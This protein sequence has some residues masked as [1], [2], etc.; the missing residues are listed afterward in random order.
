M[1][2]YDDGHDRY[3]DDNYSDEEEEFDPEEALENFCNYIEKHRRHF[4]GRGNFRGCHD[5][6]RNFHDSNRNRYSD[7]YNDKRQHHSQYN[8]D[9]TTNTA[10]GKLQNT[11]TGMS[12]HK[13]DKG[14]THSSS[15]KQ[16]QVNEVAEV[17][18]AMPYR[19]EVELD[20]PEAA[21][22]IRL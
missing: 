3:D 9:N 11:N 8:D 12:N 22:D 10:F 18:A 7:R 6:F 20:K 4:R 5:N 1:D 19:D 2:R 16:T 13:N 21:D 15:R 17:A 14:N